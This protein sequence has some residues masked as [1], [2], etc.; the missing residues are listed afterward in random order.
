NYVYEHASR[1]LSKFLLFSTF[2][3]SQEGSF[4]LWGLWTSLIALVLIP[5]ARRQRYEAQVMAIFLFVLVFISL[6][7]ITKSPFETIYSAHPS[8]APKGFVPADGK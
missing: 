1:K 7:L 2:Y 4:M 5:Y 6:M 3:A 8:E